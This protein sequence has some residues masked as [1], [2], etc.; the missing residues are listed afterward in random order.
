[1]A[2]T[3]AQGSVIS[4][5][6]GGDV[7]AALNSA[8][9]GN[10]IELQAGATFTGTFQFPNKS[11]DNNHWI[12][13][14]TSS[15]DSALPAEGQRLTP[16]YAGVASLQGRPQYSCNNP[17]NV[18]AK[19]VAK[20][21]GPIQFVSGAAYYRFIGLEVTRPAGVKGDII[22]AA[23]QHGGTS[24]NIVIDR[25]WFHGTAQDETSEGVDLS[26]TSNVA[27]VDSYFSD[28]HCTS[29]TGSCTDSHAIG[30]GLGNHQDGPYLINDNFLE[31]SGESILFG[32]GAA[33]L[34]PTDITIT[35]N[36]FWKPWQ[37]MPGNTPF[38][39]GIGGNAF[40][41][42]NHLEL[43]NAVRVLIDSNLME[44]SWGGFSQTGFGIVITP[45]NQHTP[46]GG[47]VCS[48]CQVTDITVR[49][50]HVSHAGGGFQLG[51]S[52]SGNGS[53]GA[54]ALAG[55][56]WSIHDV[57]LDDLSTKYV[58]PGVALQIGNEWP[59]NPVNTVT[60]SH[61]TA[62]PDPGAHLMFVGDKVAQAPMY[63]LVFTN[64]LMITGRYP[65]W[66]SGGGDANCAFKDVPVTTINN[67]FT[68][69]TFANNGLIA[70]PPQFPPS[71]WPSNNMFPSTVDE[72][73]FVNYNN[74]NGGNYELQPSSPYKNMGTDGK[75]L[76]ADIVTLNQA[77]ASVE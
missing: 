50:V 75:D 71:S 28:F 39:G 8:Q 10:V 59:K 33:T 44:N 1:M 66:N 67:C 30:G 17:Q 18:L 3:P 43:K 77:L 13:V 45:K 5:P 64:N 15:P 42:K 41:V 25:S 53:G 27:V 54:A 4:V 57:V 47:N 68:T 35:N 26:G 69:Y 74:G 31:A 62:F 38:V 7:Q 12:I 16:C 2:E 14:R 40:I 55:T 32:G 6:S 60:V 51:T 24:S 23:T 19:L 65:V 9:C 46:S 73:Q 37:W 70:S 11:C 48:L 76:G 52:L 29:I 72:V 63:G 58:G 20:T 21:S 36:H 22:L 56:R 49:Y 34:T 61:V